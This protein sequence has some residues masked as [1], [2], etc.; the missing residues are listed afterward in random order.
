MLYFA[1]AEIVQMRSP[2]PKLL[3]IFRDALGRENVPGVATIHYALRHIDAGAGDV[4]TIVNV[5][6]PAHRSAMDPHPHL[7][8]RMTL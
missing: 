4:R 1:F 5:H 6:D 2:L 3:E 7:K 8:L